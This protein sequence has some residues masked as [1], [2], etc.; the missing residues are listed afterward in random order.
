MALRI[1]R[2]AL[3]VSVVVYLASLSFGVAKIGDP[4][5]LLVVATYSAI[6]MGLSAAACVVFQ[7]VALV[8]NR[9][10]QTQMAGVP[11]QGKRRPTMPCFALPA[12]AAQALPN[13]LRAGRKELR[14]L[15]GSVALIGPLRL[16]CVVHWQCGAKQLSER[17]ERPRKGEPYQVTEAFS[18]LVL[19]SL[20][21]P[22]TGGF[23]ERA[24]NDH[25]GRT[26]ARV[27]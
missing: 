12:R 16:L 2:T 26:E 4:L 17:R 8:R 23:L 3:L 11:N 15:I 6:G 20:K 22:M 25:R 10:S 7:V 24:A 18:A 21:A 19:T 9:R 27:R 14:S 13:G 1:A 5:S